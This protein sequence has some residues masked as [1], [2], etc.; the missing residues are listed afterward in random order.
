MIKHFCH[1]PGCQQ[2][3]PPAMWGCTL[4]WFMLPKRLRTA[5]WN[6]YIPGQ[7]ITKTPSALYIQVVLEVQQWIT[8]NDPS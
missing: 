6:A 8:Q 1:W 3:V 2:Q 7:E 5:I 4:H